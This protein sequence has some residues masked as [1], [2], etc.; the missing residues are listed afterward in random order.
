[1]TFFRIWKTYHQCAN[2]PLSEA[3]VG[4]QLLHELN[5]SLGVRGCSWREVVSSSWPVQNGIPL[6][7]TRYNIPSN[8]ALLLPCSQAKGEQYRSQP[9]FVWIVRTSFCCIT[10]QLSRLGDI[11][12]TA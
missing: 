10:N 8:V 7:L 2:G 5:G 9:R 4:P 1:M 11:H 3:T 12:S 6:L